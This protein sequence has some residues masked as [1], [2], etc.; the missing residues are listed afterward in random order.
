MVELIL[1]DEVFAIIGSAIEVHRV[2]GR[3]FLSLFIKKRWKL[4]QHHAFFL[5]NPRKLC[6]L[7][8]K[9]VF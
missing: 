7:I 2:L 9:V 5:L 3:A 8:T 6:G 4:S 1:K